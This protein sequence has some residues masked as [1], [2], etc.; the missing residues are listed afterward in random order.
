[1]CG[2]EFIELSQSEADRIVCGFVAR[3]RELDAMLR[4]ESS[5][6]E[7]RAVVRRAREAISEF[8]R[9]ESKEWR[10]IKTLELLDDKR[11]KLSAMADEAERCCDYLDRRWTPQ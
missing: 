5:L 3:F 9:L 10:D 7:I 11:L 2:P 8:R 1:M 6:A 4:A